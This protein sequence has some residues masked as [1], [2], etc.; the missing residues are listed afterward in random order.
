MDFLATFWMIPLYPL[1]GA[2]WVLVARRWAQIV[3]PAAVGLSFLHALAAASTPRNGALEVVLYQW[4]PGID[5]G[6]LYDDL[7]RLM[8]LIVSGIGLL[9]HLYSIGYM[10][11]DTG[12]QRYFGYL[13]LFVFF[14]LLLV[15]ANNLV[16]L[17]A[18]WEGVGLASYLLIGFHFER[19]AANWAANKAFL[20]NRAGDAF[21]LLGVFLI[22]GAAA[23]VRFSS[24]GQLTATPTL[25][26]AGLCLAIGATGKSAQLPLFVWLPDAMVGPTPVSAL[27]HAATMVTA[28]IYLFVR[29]APLY[30]VIPEVGSIIAVVGVFTALL[31]ATVALVETDIKRIL[32]YSTISQLGLMFLACGVGAPEAAMFHVTTHAFFKALLFLCA[33]NIIHALHGEQDILFMGG[34]RHQMPHT[35]RLMTLGALALAGLPGL[36][37]FFSKDAILAASESSPW[38]LG[39]ALLASFLTALYS[40][41]LIWAVFFGECQEGE[42]HEAHGWMLHSLWPLAIGA[43]AGGWFWPH[44]EFHP[45]V[46]GGSAA[47]AIAGLALSR[48]YIVPG[49]FGHLF[50]RKWFVNDLYRLIFVDGVSDTIARGLYWFDRNVIDL[51]PRLTATIAAIFSH[52]S[53]WLDRFVVDGA[54]NSTSFTVKAISYPIRLLQ[55]GGLAQYALVIT[56][57][58][59]LAFA[60]F[61]GSFSGGFQ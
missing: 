47:V 22:F 24:L 39:L 51:V 57:T 36:S 4:M 35:F 9:I 43:L 54:V 45:L 46:M 19:S 27:I 23:T 26:A 34:L 60:Y 32:A 20:Y 42:A 53:T 29:M 10:K 14:M 25:M 49:P 12:L 30:S 48:S 40:G 50:A 58:L 13:N 52:T 8:V 5:F 55:T 28:G 56:I 41:R 21:Y 59:A 33:G 7:S 44:Q 38:L 61:L 17:F 31:A 16:L 11:G 3:A 1:F 6:F 18:G 15:L 37:G 2:A